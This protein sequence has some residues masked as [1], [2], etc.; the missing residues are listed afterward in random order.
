MNRVERDTLPA[1][2][3][4]AK[5]HSEK[6]YDRIVARIEANGPLAFVD[7]MQMALYEPGLGYYSAGARKFGAEGDFVTAPEISPLFSWCLA[8]QCQQIINELTGGDI[9]ELG[10]GSG[11]MA[12]ELLLELERQGCLPDHYYILEVSADCRDRQQ[13]LLQQEIPHLMSRI[14]WLNEL[15]KEKIKGVIVANEVM[16]AMPVH[17]FRHANNLQEYYVA[18]ENDQLVWQ[19]GR[20]SNNELENYLKATEISFAKGYESEANLLLLPWIASLSDSLERGAILLLD[21]GFPRHEYYHHDRDMGTLMCH[22][23][24]RAHS[25]PLIYP[26]VQDI[27]AHVDFTAV[28][29]AAVNNNLSVTGFTHQAAFLIN[30]GIGDYLQTAEDDMSQIKLAQQ[31]KQLTL[32]S[33]MGELFKAIAL[34]RGFDAPLRGFLQMNQLARL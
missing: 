4:E 5:S 6:L 12:L 32:P 25:N 16:D 3:S 23:R 13:Q 22:Y 14:Q 27:T 29:E 10:A 9:L 30:L 28:A 7:Y 31:I 18:V 11:V 15:P 24:H 8:R 2:T 21:Y 17:K 26:G 20:P 34:T 1:P 33:E 19:L